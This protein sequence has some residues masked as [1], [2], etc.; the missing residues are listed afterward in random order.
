MSVGELK[1]LQKG[2][3]SIENALIIVRKIFRKLV[4]TREYKKRAAI[5]CHKNIFFVMLEIFKERPQTEPS[6]PSIVVV[7]RNT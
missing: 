5:L 3:A 1:F 6:T 2:R 4:Q 7:W